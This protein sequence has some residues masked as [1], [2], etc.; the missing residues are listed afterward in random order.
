[1]KLISTEYDDTQSHDLSLSYVSERTLILKTW[2]PVY[3]SK[4]HSWTMPSE[5]SHSYN[6]QQC[7][8]H[9]ICFAIICSEDQSLSRTDDCHFV[10]LKQRFFDSVVPLASAVGPRLSFRKESK[11]S[12]TSFESSL[13]LFSTCEFAAVLTPNG[14]TNVYS[15]YFLFCTF[16]EL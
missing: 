16:L 11:S 6:K 5:R 8:F 9:W 15:Y 10:T 12:V 3:A 2:T 1:M 13:V 4:T 14:L 7:W